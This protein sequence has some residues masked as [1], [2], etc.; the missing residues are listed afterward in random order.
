MVGDREKCLAAQMDV[1]YLTILPPRLVLTATGLPLQT[2]SPEPARPDYSPMRDNG[3]WY[4]RCIPRETKPANPY[5]G[6]NRVV[7]QRN[8]ET[9]PIG[10]SRLH[11]T[12]NGDCRVAQAAGGGPDG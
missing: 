10:S 4:L 6:P 12:N 9:P 5:H 1:S 7:S 3:W 2:S 11:G 8:P